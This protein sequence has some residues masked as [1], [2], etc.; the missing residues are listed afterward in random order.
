MVVVNLMDVLKDHVYE[1]ETVEGMQ[2]TDDHDHD[3]DDH[4]HDDHDHDDHD[5]D[6]H[7]GHENENDEHI[8]LSLHNASVAC[9]A[10]ADAMGKL[11]KEHADTYRTNAENYQKQLDELNK[12]YRQVVDSAAIKTIVVAD[13]FPFRYLTADY[14]IRY[15]A[16][17]AGCSAESEASFDTIIFLAKKVD[18]LGLKVILTTENTTGSVAETVKENTAGKNQ[19]ILA[20]DSMQS[21]SME[22][23]K[24]GTTY[25]SVMKKNL[26][27]LREAL[28]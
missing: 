3:H 8:W 11:D 1:E 12:Q 17:F 4:D 15:Y 7:E 20:L 25:L 18:E 23:V 2:K 16:A 22:N 21:V 13:R 19:K 24:N 5:H 6:D 28:S 27:V 14:D 26:E 10:V 9:D